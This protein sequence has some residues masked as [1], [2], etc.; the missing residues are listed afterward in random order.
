[1]Q[2]VN[3]FDPYALE[4]PFDEVHAADRTK[5]KRRG[6]LVSVLVVAVVGIGAWLRGCS[7][8]W[9]AQNIPPEAL[10]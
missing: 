8:V 1:M 3:E 5:K 10:W 6:A 2:E 9:R 7:Q 4:D